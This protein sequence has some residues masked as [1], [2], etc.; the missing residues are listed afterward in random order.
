MKAKLLSAGGGAARRRRKRVARRVGRRLSAIPYR[1]STIRLNSLLGDLTL[2]DAYSFEERRR[3]GGDLVCLVAGHKRDL[4]HVVLPYVEEAAD[5]KCVC[6][7][8]PGIY[9][10]ALSDVCAQW[11]WSYLST[12]TRDAFLAQ[13][14]CF[15]LHDGADLIVRIDEDMILPP[16]SIDALIER[17]LRIRDAGVL[18]PG[19][20]APL[21]PIDGLGCRYVLEA[22]GLLERFELRFGKA[23]IHATETPV[24]TNAEAAL[25][26]WE[27]T[28]PLARTAEILA[29][30]PERLLYVPIVPD[31]GM[32]VFER[33]FWDAIGYLPLRR[34]HRLFGRNDDTPDAGY[35]C[36]RAMT[37]SRPVIITS[38]VVAGRFAHDAHY[39][40]MQ[41]HLDAQ[42]HLFVV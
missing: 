32:I 13:S 37:L 8:S 23:R 5:G 16:N 27:N 28:A 34:R 42:P 10:R 6:V 18:S 26:V 25:W 1:P 3:S 38:R 21:V 39:E 30:E 22:M 24:E 19:A 35:I 17:Y 31:T 36:S 7:V 33:S 9:D 41:G 29:G 11:G 14:I 12:A 40:A 20:L 15:E 2:V 4:W